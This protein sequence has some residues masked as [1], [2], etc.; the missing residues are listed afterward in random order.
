M[1]A[2][3]L[4][5]I[6]SNSAEGQDC[7]TTDGRFC[8]LPFRYDNIKYDGCTVDG[9]PDGLR[10]CSTLV[11]E[12]GDH[13]S[14]AG[15][16]GYCDPSCPTATVNLPPSLAPTSQP[17]YTPSF[18]PTLEP[19][20]QPT[21]LPTA[22]PSH[23]PTSR[24]TQI[25]SATPSLNPTSTPTFPP[26]LADCHAVDSPDFSPCV[27]PFHVNGKTYTG[28]TTEAWPDLSGSDGERRCST[29]IDTTNGNHV[30]G[31]VGKCSP[32][33]DHHVP[34]NCYWFMGRWVCFKIPTPSPTAAPTPSPTAA[35]TPSP[36]AAPTAAPISNSK[37]SSLGLPLGLIFGSVLLML[38]IGFSWRK[39]QNASNSTTH[40]AEPLLAG[41]CIINSGVDVEM[42]AMPMAQSKLNQIEKISTTPPPAFMPAATATH[43]V[44]EVAP[45]ANDGLPC[46]LPMAVPKL[47]ALG[48]RREGFRCDFCCKPLQAMN[49]LHTGEWRVSE[50]SLGLVADLGPGK[51]AELDGDANANRDE[52]S[53]TGVRLCGEC[54]VGHCP[55]CGTQLVP[56]LPHSI[57]SSAA[58]GSH[59]KVA[60]GVK[61]VKWYTQLGKSDLV[62][63]TFGVFPALV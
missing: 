63:I 61:T 25:P 19:T 59:S 34:S 28:C 29:E 7:T 21:Q 62:R 32:P 16:W 14:G 30:D 49:T 42:A 5:V 17:T 58:A 40:L 41:T 53:H 43:T 45:A 2:L 56:H 57:S 3:L 6:L 8:S 13:V 60:A 22:S 48:T 52:E 35:P 47:R 31:K 9:D 38:M 20:D 39:K 51:E 44:V 36:T 33:C 12:A 15:E 1:F 24:P 10:W 11:D 4:R 46:D 50:G 37:K 54:S 27:F 55:E 23:S 26:T 18:A